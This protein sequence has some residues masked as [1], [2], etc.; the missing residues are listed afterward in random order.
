MGVRAPLTMTTEFKDMLIYLVKEWWG[1]KA[2][3]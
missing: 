3:I 1:E 2:L